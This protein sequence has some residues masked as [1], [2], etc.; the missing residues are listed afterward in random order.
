MRALNHEHIFVYPYLDVNGMD[1]D[2]ILPGLQGVANKVK[3]NS[4]LKKVF[5]ELGNLYLSDGDYLLHG[6]YFPGSWLKTED[7]IKII[8]P[9]FCFFGPIEFEIGVIVTHLKMAD[10]PVAI[11]QRALSLY[12][13]EINFRAPDLGGF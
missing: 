4:S 7:G 3:A 2:T 10:Q 9:E 6:D 5:D 8:D 12:D 13:E 1:L 11:I